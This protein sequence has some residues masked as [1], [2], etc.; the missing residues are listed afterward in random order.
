MKVRFL[1]SKL[2]LKVIKLQDSIDVRVDRALAYYKL[3]K[4]E[5]CRKDVEHVL[6]MDPQNPIANKLAKHL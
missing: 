2:I 4:M 6:K 5:E 3:R 1:L